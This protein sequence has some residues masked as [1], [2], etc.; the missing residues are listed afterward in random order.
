QYEPVLAREP[1]AAVAANNLAWMLMQQD[2]LD[3]AL[4]YALVAKAELRHSPQV[5]DT[6][7]WIYFQ[8]K[9]LRD[10]V[11]LVAEAAERQPES[12]IY[13]VHLEAIQEALQAEGAAR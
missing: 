7:G 5:N 6:L 13:R 1:R 10:A 12:E 8:R 9:Q 11:P 2:R 4:R 3:D